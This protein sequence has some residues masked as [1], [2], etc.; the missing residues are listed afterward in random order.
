MELF[1]HVLLQNTDQPIDKY[2]LDMRR[3]NI[4]IADIVGEPLKYVKFAT[5]QV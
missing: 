1:T 2:P 3:A 4:K 5:L